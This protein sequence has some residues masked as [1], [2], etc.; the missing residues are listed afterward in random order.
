MRKVKKEENCL[1]G[2]VWRF[3]GLGDPA[4]LEKV[5]GV[6]ERERDMR[7]EQAINL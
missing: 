7:G 4:M 1:K 2:I 3:S 6:Y 5:G